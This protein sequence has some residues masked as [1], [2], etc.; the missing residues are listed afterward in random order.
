MQAV[1]F[2]LN[3]GADYLPADP[4][5]LAGG[6]SSYK[7]ALPNDIKTFEQFQVSLIKGLL[8]SILLCYS[9][10][11]VDRDLRLI[12]TLSARAQPEGKGVVINDKSHGYHAVLYLSL[13]HI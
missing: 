6:V 3:C 5:Y 9:Y 7:T 1:V 10:S 2:T 8:D 11:T 12:T 4:L 13:I